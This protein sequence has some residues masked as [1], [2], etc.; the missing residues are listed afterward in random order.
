MDYKEKYKKML[1]DIG[2]QPMKAIKAFCFQCSGYD[3][4]EVRECSC[5]ECALYILKKNKKRPK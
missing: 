1:E 2:T 4:K 3:Y 5:K